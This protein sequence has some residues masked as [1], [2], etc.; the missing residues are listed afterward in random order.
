MN[1]IQLSQKP[2]PFEAFEDIHQAVLG[3]ISD[4]MASL[5]QSGEYVTID[6]DD[7]SINRYDVINFISESYTLQ[8]ST[9]VDWQIVTDEKLVVKVQYL[10]SM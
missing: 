6:T 10:C 5:D 8:N 7:T 3:V 9:T 1:I 2:T 4:N